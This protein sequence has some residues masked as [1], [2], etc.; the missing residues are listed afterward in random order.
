MPQIFNLGGIKIQKV[1]TLQ[2]GVLKD[3][4]GNYPILETVYDPAD[5]HKQDFEPKQVHSFNWRNVSQLIAKNGTV[6]NVENIDEGLP[7][8]REGWLATETYNEFE[9]VEYDGN[10]YQVP[11][12]TNNIPGAAGVPGDSS[13]VPQNGWTRYYS[14]E[15]F[16]E[17]LDS[18]E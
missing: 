6:I 14:T 13:G 7:T 1:T 8:F 4:S 11:A 10:Y 16:A 2:V 9:V 5:I 3:F 18:G 17:I 15:I 12:D